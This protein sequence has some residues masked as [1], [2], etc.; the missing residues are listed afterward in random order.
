ATLPARTGLGSSSSFT[1]ALMKG[2]A[3]HRGDSRTSR[4]IAEDACRI[5][6]EA[7]GEPIGKQ[8]QYTAAFGGINVFTFNRS[9]KTTRRALHLST[10]A[11]RSLE[12]SM[13][14]FYTG[15]TRNAADVLADQNER[16][17]EHLEHYRELTGLVPV[18]ADALTRGD[19]ETMGALLAKGWKH[20]RLLGKDV[21]N[22]VLDALY[23]SACAAGAYGG[24]VVGAGGGGCL[25]FFTPRGQ[26][27]P[28]Q[29]VLQEEALRLR[30]SES[31][32]IPVRIEPEGAQILLNTI[33]SIKK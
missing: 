5:E 7:L 28:I 6:I 19:A 2:L 25:L 12:E 3:A 18:F 24:K 15:T 31:R 10:N 17:P 33:N 16:V 32:S 11:K 8:D 26:R 9:G 27:E 23:E 1:V 29:K 13:V 14:L 22:P 4:E 21:T 20:K 30:L